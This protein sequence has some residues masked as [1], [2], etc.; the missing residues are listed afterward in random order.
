M[1]I[2]THQGGVVDASFN[3]DWRFVFPLFR[4]S[5]L[6]CRRLQ[7]KI[8]SIFLKCKFLGVP[9]CEN[10][11]RIKSYLLV[12]SRGLFGSRHRVSGVT[13]CW[14]GRGGWRFLIWAVHLQLGQLL[15]EIST[16][17]VKV[18]D[19]TADTTMILAI[20][21]RKGLSLFIQLLSRSLAFCLPVCL[22]VCL[23][24]G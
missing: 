14:Y 4:F 6:F 16:A 11:A 21:V 22:F 23:F 17:F 7:K 15:F 20:F 1:N 3:Q 12:A 24:V 13:R 2:F 19:L 5:R 9:W 18:W 8:V 10:Q